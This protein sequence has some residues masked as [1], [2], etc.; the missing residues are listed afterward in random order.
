MV[1]TKKEGPQQV[2]EQPQLLAGWVDCAACQPT[3]FLC[4]QPS[5]LLRRIL[6]LLAWDCHYAQ[7]YYTAGGRTWPSSQI[8]TCRS[9]RINWHIIA[10][11]CILADRI[12]GS[13]GKGMTI[14]KGTCVTTNSRRDLGATQSSW[15]ELHYASCSPEFEKPHKKTTPE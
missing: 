12:I 5:K 6:I 4:E 15:E 1:Y 13:L 2:L 7:A 3:K 14:A 9:R 11:P 8:C 10:R